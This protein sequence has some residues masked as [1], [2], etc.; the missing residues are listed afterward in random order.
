MKKFT[1]ILLTAGAIALGGFTAFAANGH[2]FSPEKRLAHMKKALNLTDAQVAQIKDVYKSNAATFKAD[3][4][5]MKAAAKGSDAKKDAF[6]KM[7]ADMRAM[8][9][10]ITPI[11]TADQQAKWQ[12]MMQ[13]HEH[14]H[15]RDRDKDNNA[16]AAGK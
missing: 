13:K 7:R 16:G 15:W 9:S 3:R 10:Q 8:R 5:A 2:H 12:Q 1:M 11:L 14:G 6:Q 4:A